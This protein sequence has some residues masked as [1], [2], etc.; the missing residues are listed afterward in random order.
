[1]TGRS[2]RRSRPSSASCRNK[3]SGTRGRRGNP[4]PPGRSWRRADRVSAPS[5]SAR[6]TDTH[7][8]SARAGSGR[9]AASQRPRE[10]DRGAARTKDAPPQV[11]Q[12]TRFF[13]TESA[14]ISTK[15][16]QS[17][18]ARGGVD[19]R[20]SASIGSAASIMWSRTCCAVAG[21]M[22]GISC[23]PD[24]FL[25]AERER[26]GGHRSVRLRTAVPFHRGQCWPGAA[27][28]RA[29]CRSFQRAKLNHAGLEPAPDRHGE[30]RQTAEQRR[31]SKAS[32]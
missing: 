15:D 11:P 28:R 23:S 8:Q 7:R 21:P 12:A 5:E 17:S 26:S 6:A 27:R 3:R 16:S 29:H 19:A 32:G 10:S 22:P 9:H 24:R 1:M 31:V 2:P 25:S 18:P 13:L 14:C 20:A 30:P 4:R